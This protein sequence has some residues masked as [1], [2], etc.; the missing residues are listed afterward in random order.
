MDGK[1]ILLT[2]FCGTS[3]ET[4]VKGAE[5]NLKFKVLYLPNDKIKDSELLIEALQQ[6]QFDYVISLGQRP[7]IKDKIHI[8]TLARKGED[9]LI[10]AFEYERLKGC[11]E[12]NG[13][14]VK[15]SDNAGT[16]YCNELY[17]NGLRYILERELDT[18]MVFIHV[19]FEKN[20][21]N[22]K[23]FVE[24]MKVILNFVNKS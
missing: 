4:L 19:P 9:V 12:Q 20:I 15:I 2:A 17:W 11:L 22:L 23:H 5:L 6:K 1:R 7:N 10:T 16:S 21:S 18:Q 13:L 3:A 8:E 24:E 14:S